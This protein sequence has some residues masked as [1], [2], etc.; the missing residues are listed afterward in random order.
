MIRYAA[1]LFLSLCLVSGAKAADRALL[2]G[3]GTYG[4]LPE[5]MFLKGPKND[6]PLIEKLLKE[7][8]GYAAEAIRILID[9]DATKAAILASID[10]WLVAGTQPGDRVY[11]YFSGHGLQVKDQNGEEEDGLDEALSTFDIA[12]S[13]GDWTNVI[14]DDDIDA[15][16]AKL[17]DRAVSIVIDACHSGT[18][19]RSLSANVADTMEGARFLP[20]PFAKPVE[21]VKTRGLRIDVAVVDKPE[22]AK[23]NGVEAWS[24]ASSYQVAWDDTRLPPEE[25]HGVFTLSYVN[26]HEIPTGDSNGNGIVSNAE[27]LEYV[28]TQ[29]KTYCAAQ[30]KCQGLDPQLEVNYALLGASAVTPTADTAGQQDQQAQTGGGTQQQTPDYGK[31]E[32]VKVENT[33]QTAYVAAD[34]VDAVGDILG[35]AQT[36]DVT[37][38]LSSDHLNNGDV[39]K[40]IVTSATGGHLILYD[41]AKDGKATQIFPNESAQKITPLTAN[42]SLTIPDDYY[43]FDFEA[44]G[45]SENVLVAIVVA[46]DVDLTEVAPADYGLTKDLDARTTIADIAGTLKQTWTRDTENRSVNWS[47]GLL[48][49]AVY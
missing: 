28:K 11:V 20:R 40:I 29:S 10:E 8:H 31:V 17:K 36:G 14:L 15:M 6:V 41:V 49:Y 9:K 24:A 4:S 19:S 35:K 37:V 22:I 12:A 3:I 42:V 2:I 16:L 25:R 44:E 13:N 45:P 33:Q 1:A 18:I 5:K 27:L 32:E 47:L 38:A 21:A 43:G 46:D 26:G 34:P 48:K 30:T 23:Q 39:F 7:K